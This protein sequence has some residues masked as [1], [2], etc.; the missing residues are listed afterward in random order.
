MESGFKP[1]RGSA[2]KSPDS[3]AGASKEED[4][5]RD[6]QGRSFPRMIFD[7]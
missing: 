3:E 5:H 1:L 4:E 2:K 7:P 6:A